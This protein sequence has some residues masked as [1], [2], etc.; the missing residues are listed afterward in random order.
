MTVPDL[1]NYTVND[2]LNMFKDAFYNQNNSPMI[3]GSDDYAASAMM[4]YVLDVLVNAINHCGEMRFLDTATGQWLDTMAAIFG[5][6]RP[7][8]AASSALFHLTR[9]TPGTFNVGDLVVS[10]GQVNFTNREPIYLSGDVDVILYCDTA[11]SQYN[12]IP[13]NAIETIISGSSLI[14]AATNTTITGGGTDGFPY[15]EEGDNG[16]REYIKDRRGTFTVGGSAPAYKS[17]AFTIDSRVRDVY[18]VQ[19][20]DS[21]YEKGKVKISVLWDK[22]TLDGTLENLLNGQI[23]NAC[24]ADDFR[25]IGDLIEVYSASGTT[26][27]PGVKVVYPLKFQDLAVGHYL[28]TMKA[29]KTYLASKFN[30]AYSESELAKR[31]ITPDE[32]GVYALAYDDTNGNAEY[33]APEPGKYL[34][35]SAYASN[36]LDDYITRGYF[37]F[38]DTG[39]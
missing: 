2:I 33:V 34:N 7:P 22:S 35:L 13:V 28:A 11:G 5:L 16:F 18:I 25:A 37:V 19:D 9:I 10:D 31:F 1:L 30:R 21:N 6:S 32:N 39:E 24:S 29:Y 38:V 27:I 17:K 3:I 20:G 26:L 12:G 15:T 14:S 36:D 23:L 4:S 8:A